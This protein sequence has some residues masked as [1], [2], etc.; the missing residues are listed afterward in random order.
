MIT[1][2]LINSDQICIGFGLVS[3]NHY[4]FRGI[5]EVLLANSLYI[6]YTL[7]KPIMPL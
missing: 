5:R 4:T 2:G 1:S 7:I 3:Q 6:L